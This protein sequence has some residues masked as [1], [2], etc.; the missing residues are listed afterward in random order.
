MAS[1]YRRRDSSLEAS[2]AV[3]V[4][5]PSVNALGS[6]IPVFITAAS[7]NELHENRCFPVPSL[8]PFSGVKAR[9]MTKSKH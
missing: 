3:S 4:P 1:W 9:R 8:V 2:F 7:A 5:F 6:A